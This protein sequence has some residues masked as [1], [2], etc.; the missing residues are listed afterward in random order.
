MK[1][2]WDV[3][4]L[5]RAGRTVDISRLLEQ[6]AVEQHAHRLDGVQRDPL[7]AL[8]DVLAQ[9]L[10]QSGNEPRQ[11]IAHGLRSQRLQVERSEAALA[12]SP[13]RPLFGELGTGERKDEERVVAGPLQQV[14][15]E[16]EQA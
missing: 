5:D 3:E 14:L 7:R 8:E 6:A 11:Q 15:E 1:R 10:G 12:G 9:L 13:R 2:L 16:V 4:R